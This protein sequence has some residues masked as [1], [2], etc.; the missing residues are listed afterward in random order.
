MCKTRR[1]RYKIYKRGMTKIRGHYIT[2]SKVSK[3]E[4]ESTITAHGEIDWGETKIG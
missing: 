3:N 4:H 2:R 1:G